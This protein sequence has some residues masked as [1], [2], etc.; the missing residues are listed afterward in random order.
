MDCFLAVAVLSF[1]TQYKQDSVLR[2]LS[3]KSFLSDLYGILVVDLIVLNIAAIVIYTLLTI[4][5]CSLCCAQI[6][7]V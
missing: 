6:W 5:L 4:A 3:V 7:M 1:K 2:T